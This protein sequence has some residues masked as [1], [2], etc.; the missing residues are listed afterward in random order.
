M[1]RPT[2]VVLFLVATLVLATAC[3]RIELGGGAGGSGVVVDPVDVDAMVEEELAAGN[4]ADASN[5]LQQEGN[6]L[7]EGIPAAVQE[8]IDKLYVAG[9]YNVWFTG[10]EELGGAKISASIAVELPTDSAA[11]A[12]LLQI[13][14]DFWGADPTPD[15]GQRYLSFYFD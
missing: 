11:R 14:A 1:V 6:M 8:L 2:T 7:F 15:E 5:W 13:E 12:E 9:A 3:F 10:I 4:Y